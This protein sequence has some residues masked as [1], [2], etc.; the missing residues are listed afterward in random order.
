MQVGFDA[1]GWCLGLI[2]I[3]AGPSSGSGDAGAP[4]RRKVPKDTA[5][6]PPI[7]RQLWLQWQERV[8]QI[9][10]LGRRSFFLAYACGACI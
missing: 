4:T 5:F 8:L 10:P 7:R 3:G 6:L 9:G 1:C 2:T